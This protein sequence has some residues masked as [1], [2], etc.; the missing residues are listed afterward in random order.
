MIELDIEHSQVPS[1]QPSHEAKVHKGC[2]P[3]RGRRQKYKYNTKYNTN[4]YNTKYTPPSGVFSFPGRAR[5]SREVVRFMYAQLS[6]KSPKN[7]K[8]NADACTLHKQT[9]VSKPQTE[10]N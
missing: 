9:F 10:D 1:V 6:R 7:R 5:R 2:H 4:T 3:G 8:T